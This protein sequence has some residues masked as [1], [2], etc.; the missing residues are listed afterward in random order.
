MND[1]KPTPDLEEL[2]EL[3]TA[4]SQLR[5]QRRAQF[6]A[7]QGE[8]SLS[9]R[10]ERLRQRESV[11]ADLHDLFDCLVG[12]DLGEQ[13]PPHD[14]GALK[15]LSAVCEELC[16]DR[17]LPD[18][19][20]ARAVLCLASLHAD[21]AEPRIGKLF[22]QLV[23]DES[24][25]IEVRKQAYTGHF[26]LAGRSVLEWPDIDFDFPKDVDWPLVDRFA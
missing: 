3:K 2:R 14:R 15:T 8:R 26:E 7:G 11:A 19:E 21:S 22:V 13:A 23:K 16:Q 18:V 17:N 6:G 5:A 9:R 20:R 4:L 25:P 24:Q 12:C 10:S 1:S